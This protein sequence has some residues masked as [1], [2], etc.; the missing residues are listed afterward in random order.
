MKKIRVLLIDDDVDFCKATKMMLEQAGYELVIAY[1]GKKG[2]ECAKKENPDLV[3]IDVMLPDIN[4]FSVCRELKEDP[5]YTALPVLILTSVGAD[6][7][8]YAEK[9]AEG[10]Q[11]DAYLSKPVTSKQLMDTLSKMLTA[12]E[13][14]SKPKE[15]KARILLVDDDKDFLDATKRILAANLY[16]VITATDGEEGIT[17]AMQKNPDLIVLDVMMPGK[18]GYSVCYELRKNAK[19]R[20]L[21]IIML[22]AVG[23]QL[24]QPEYAVDMAIDHLADDFID[25]PVDATTLLKKIDKHLTFHK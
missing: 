19:T 18:D 20:S 16:E 8:S 25:K 3:I 7:K 22:T 9:I 24:A 10:H 11:A 14:P 4:G 15:V 5:L 21:P 6:A 2:L 17:M 23:Q 1:D 13:P 12:L